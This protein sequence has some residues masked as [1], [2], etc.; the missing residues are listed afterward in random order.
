[1][2]LPQHFPD[3]LCTRLGDILTKPS[4][5]S[6][7][8][9]SCLWKLFSLLVTLGLALGSSLQGTQ[10]GGAVAWAGGQADGSLEDG[11]AQP[12]AL[13]LLSMALQLPLH[14]CR[15]RSGATLP[16]AGH[17]AG[18]LEGLA[19]PRH[20]APRAGR[21]VLRQW[22]R[23]PNKG[24]IFMQLSPCPELCLCLWQKGSYPRSE[25]CLEPVQGIGFQFQQRLSF[26]FFSYPSSHHRIIPIPIS[27]PPSPFL[28]L[29]L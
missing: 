8:E 7:S 25:H 11:L 10:H 29:P 27:L 6:L 3:V 22:D 17:S 9:A 16:Q 20:A 15:W 19:L 1:M 18:I 28:S 13:S 23:P 14:G 26:P 4:V 21:H 24:F 2:R 12:P 5:P